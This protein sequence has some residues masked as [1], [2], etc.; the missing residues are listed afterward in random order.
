MP[1]SSPGPLQIKIDNL[2]RII[3]QKDNKLQTTGPQTFDWSN[4][5]KYG[6]PVPSGIYHAEI[7]QNGKRVSAKRITVLK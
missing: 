1:G 6:K 2:G 5:D 7:V 4:S 3:Q